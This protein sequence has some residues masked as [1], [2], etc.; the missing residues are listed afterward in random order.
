MVE[1]NRCYSSG[2]TQNS[3][4]PTHD[5]N[6]VMVFDPEGATRKANV[7]KESLIPV[8]QSRIY[9]GFIVVTVL[10][11]KTRIGRFFE[12][13]E[14]ENEYIFLRTQSNDANVTVIY[15]PDCEHM[16]E[17][18]DFLLGM[19]TSTLLLLKLWFPNHFKIHFPASD[20][21]IIFLIFL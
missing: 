15:E 10:M 4:P 6:V 20:L 13:M 16:N 12:L 19:W 5:W 9:Y 8:G 2:T 7:D 1:I 14:E 11:T 3:D 18:E 21:V 17:N